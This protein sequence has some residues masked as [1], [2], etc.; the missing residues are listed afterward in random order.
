M[1][2][3]GR[4][5]G[6]LTLYDATTT[7]IRID[8]KNNFRMTLEEMYHPKLVFRIKL[9]RKTFYRKAINQA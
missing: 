8:P 5:T 9:N 6:N 3:K 1:P 7:N 2:N 4:I